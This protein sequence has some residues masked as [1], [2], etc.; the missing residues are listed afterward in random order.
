MNNVRLSDT[1]TDGLPSVSYTREFQN[2]LENHTLLL[3]RSS[4]VQTI[5]V[6]N[7]L[8][9]QYD[10]DFF[11][12]LTALLVPSKYHWI[13]MRC[14]GMYSPTDYKLSMTSVILPNFDEIDELQGM[15]NAS[16]NLAIG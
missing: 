8:A 13:V 7:G 11:G 3:L 1:I 6:E 2:M 12:L 9:L 15:F 10:S 4:G 5:G 16:N 14:N